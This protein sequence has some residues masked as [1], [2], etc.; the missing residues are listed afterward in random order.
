MIE[1][2]N[3]ICK[4]KNMN[5]AKYYKIIQI[6]IINNLCVIVILIIYIYIY[7]YTILIIYI[8]LQTH[9]AIFLVVLGSSSLLSTLI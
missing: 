7:I 1:M 4:I 3:L 5:I 9:E 8:Y 2:N 6:Y